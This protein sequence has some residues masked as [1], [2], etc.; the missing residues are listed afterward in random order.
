[1]APEI[2]LDPVDAIAVGAVGPAGHRAFYIQARSRALRLTVLL[3]KLHVQSL[4]Q[5]TIELMAGQQVEAV[6]EPEP[7]TEPVE[8]DWRA[9]EV[10]LGLD[11]E[12]N[13]FVLLVREVQA[14]E[15]EGNEAAAASLAT[16][17]L[18]I[19]PAQML[20]FAARGLEL[21]RAGRPLCQVCGL[22]MDPEGHLCP[23]K[24]GKSPI[25]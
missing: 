17:R 23:R 1:V 11:T 3:E 20:A 7:L 5:R 8:A 22:P 18:W 21:V 2:E 10:G 16:A 14:A 15:D 4:A 13:R 24:N 19:R 6:E 9:G 25:F 12:S